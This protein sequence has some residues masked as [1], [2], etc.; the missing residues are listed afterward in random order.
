MLTFL[1]FNNNKKLKNYMYLSNF[2]FVDL[3]NK[4]FK[5]ISLRIKQNNNNF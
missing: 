3:K 4:E 5:I 1:K 2:L